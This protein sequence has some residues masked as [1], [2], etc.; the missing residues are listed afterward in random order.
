MDQ[1]KGLE[2]RISKE[3]TRTK[4][5]M[6][7][8]EIPPILIRIS[9]QDQ[10]SR[11][12]ITIRI[13]K[14]H[15]INA[16]INHSKETMEIDLEIDLS[17]I[18]METG[19]KM[20]NIIVLHRPKGE[21]SR[22]IIHTANQQVINQTI[23]LSADLTTDLQPGSHSANK[24]SHKTITKRHLMWFVSLRSTIPLTN[25]QTSVR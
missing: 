12:G 20:E 25:Y 13:I 1:T 2:T 6:G 7:L 10:T 14:E 15:M 5:T 19:E 4:L 18:R 16:Q 11:M 24:N 21:I 8:G 17:T 9:L 22:K 23:L 3:E